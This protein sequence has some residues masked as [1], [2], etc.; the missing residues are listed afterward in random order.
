MIKEEAA[1]S[2]RR[3]K[4]FLAEAVVTGDLDHPNI[5]PIYDVGTNSEGNLFYSMKKVQGDP[6]MNVIDQKSLAEN[7]DILM[8]T[9]DAV[10]FA[11]ARGIVHRDLKPENIMLGEFGEVLVMDWGLAHPLAGYRKSNSVAS[12]KSMGGTPAYM[13][14]EMVTGPLEKIGPAEAIFICWV[15]YF[16]KL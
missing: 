13:S 1:K 2:E 5:V 11:H 8:R 9:A 15:P 4:K 3:N 6:W 10:G 16:M 14:P 12:S 7:L